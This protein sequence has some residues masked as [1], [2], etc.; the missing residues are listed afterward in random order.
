MDETSIAKAYSK[1]KGTVMRPSVWD[2]YSALDM[3]EHVNKSKTHSY[4]SYCAMI[5]SE[6]LISRILPQVLL[7]NRKTMN[8]SL[9]QHGDIVLGIQTHL[10]V[11]N[12]SWMTQEIFLEILELLLDALEPYMDYYDFILVFDASRV[13]LSRDIAS[14]MMIA[15]VRIVVVPAKLTWLLQPLDTHIF[16][17]F[18]NTLRKKLHDMAICVEN[19]VIDD[20]KWIDTVAECIQLLQETTDTHM[21]AFARNGMLGN[22]ECMKATEDKVFDASFLR[23]IQRVPPSLEEIEF[24]LGTKTVPW[25]DQVIGDLK[26]QLYLKEHG[27]W[28]N[29]RSRPQM[30]IN[31]QS[32]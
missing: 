32:Q 26:F 15:G 1:N 10:W 16:A 18:K 19:G 2:D 12:S 11:R 24:S 22:Q 20:M 17:N 7:A 27:G 25:Y 5:A 13:H 29:S 14:K 23:S 4:I 28:G 6:P 21:R 31:T 8:R 3:S 9:E 30:T